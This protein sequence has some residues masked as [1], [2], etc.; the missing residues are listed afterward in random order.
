MLPRGIRRRRSGCYS[1]WQRGLSGWLWVQNRF[2]P[3]SFNLSVCVVVLLCVYCVK[4]GKG[5]GGGSDSEI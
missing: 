3:L 5:G 1:R 4:E 2:V